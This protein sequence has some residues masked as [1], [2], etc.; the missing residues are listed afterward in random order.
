[1]KFF[2][3]IKREDGFTIQEVLVVLIVGSIL[4]GLSL[5]L[6]LFTNRLFLT[7]SGTNDLKSETNRILHHMAFDIQQSR[8]LVEHTDT[9]FVLSKSVG[10]VV[11]YSY[12]GKTLQ[13]NDVE[14]TPRKASAVRVKVVEEQNLGGRLDRAPLFHITVLVQSALSDYTTEMDAAPAPSSRSLFMQSRIHQ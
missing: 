4:V 3:V 13:R 14:M 12:N 11:R 8:E 7:W 2:T 9:S 6:F 5:S 1:M 10:R